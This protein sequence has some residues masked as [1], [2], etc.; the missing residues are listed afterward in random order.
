MGTLG[1]LLLFIVTMWG[2][3][4]KEVAEILKRMARRRGRTSLN[5]AL[6]S[7]P[8]DAEVVSVPSLY[9]VVPIEDI[10]AATTI[11]EADP[12]DAT[13]TLER[14]V[15]GT[16]RCIIHRR[17]LPATVDDYTEAQ[18]GDADRLKTHY[19][20]DIK[21]I[22]GDSADDATPVTIRVYNIFFRAFKW[23]GTGT[24]RDV[25]TKTT[26]NRP[27]LLV[28]EDPW[29]DFYIVNSNQEFNTCTAK[30]TA[31]FDDTDTTITVDNVELSIGISPLEDPTDMTET[32]EVTNRWGFEG[33]DNDDMEIAYNYTEEYWYLRQKGC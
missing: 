17:Y 19:Q 11:N 5:K 1:Y 7:D 9:V 28:A 14:L 10:T 23:K 31:A 2:F 3:R 12:L 25:P 33:A 22:T 32:L 13:Q 8:S 30:A 24:G 21:G 29:G 20:R 4:D 26:K 6:Y 18:N 16:G 15:L 27:T